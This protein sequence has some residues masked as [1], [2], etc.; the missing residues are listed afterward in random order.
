MEVGGGGDYEG[1]ASRMKGSWTTEED[2]ILHQLVTKFGPRNWGMI[3]RGIPGRSGKSWR[4]RWCNQL[5]PAVKHKPF[6][7]LANLK[8]EV[9]PIIFTL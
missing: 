4:L 9:S 3:V 8:F 7:G 5:D 1:T 2:V 6:S